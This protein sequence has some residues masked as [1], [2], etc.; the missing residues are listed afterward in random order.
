[1]LRTQLSKLSSRSPSFRMAV[2]AEGCCGEAGRE[3]SLAHGKPESIGPACPDLSQLRHR[4]EVLAC[5]TVQVGTMAQEIWICGSAT[6][7]HC[8]E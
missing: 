6:S 8:R 3:I 2:N 7:G 5:P 4:S 1:M